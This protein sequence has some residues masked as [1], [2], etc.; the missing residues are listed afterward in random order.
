MAEYLQTA[1]GHLAAPLVA[2]LDKQVK[3]LMISREVFAGRV[4]LLKDRGL[5]INTMDFSPSRDDMLAWIT[6]N[7]IQDLGIEVSQFKVLA[8]FVFYCP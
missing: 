3:M 7:F 2:E 8:K 1:M 6:R 5:I 4:A